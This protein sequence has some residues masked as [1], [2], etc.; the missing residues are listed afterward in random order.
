DAKQKTRPLTL[1]VAGSYNQRWAVWTKRG[2]SVSTAKGGIPGLQPGLEHACTE[3]AE[4]KEEIQL[5]LII[6]CT[7]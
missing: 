6:A 1:A 4:A 5:L 3:A 7:S 2:S